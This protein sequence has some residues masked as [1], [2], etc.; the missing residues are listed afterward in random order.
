M[1]VVAVRLK[2]Q[3]NS[4][5]FAKTLVRKDVASAS[6]SNPSDAPSEDAQNPKEVNNDEFTSKAQVMTLMTTDVDRVS[7]FA[8]HFYSL[9]GKSPA[10]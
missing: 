5:L 3:L 10:V 7:E 9:V 1:N 6:A 8:W 4:V 2:T